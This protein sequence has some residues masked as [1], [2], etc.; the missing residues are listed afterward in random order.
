MVHGKKRETMIVVRRDEHKMR[1]VRSSAQSLARL[2]EVSELGIADLQY[3]R[4]RKALFIDVLG[5]RARSRFAGHDLHAIGGLDRGEIRNVFEIKK[6]TAPCAVVGVGA[7]E[8]RKVRR[9]SAVLDEVEPVVIIDPRRF[10]RSL[11]RRSSTG[12][13]EREPS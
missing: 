6:P 10:Q 3:A 7:V 9:V 11:S 1:I 5:I 12:V 8:N 2:A 13:R 4:Q